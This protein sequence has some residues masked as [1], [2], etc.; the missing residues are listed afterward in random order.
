[1]DI[2]KVLDELDKLFAEKRSGE[3]ENF[4]KGKLRE[5]EEVDD[6]NSIITLVNELIGFYRVSSQY[7][8]AMVYSDYIISLMESL[9]LNNTIPFATT[10]LNIATAYRAAGKSEEALEYYE[11][12]LPIYNEKLAADDFRFASL[13]N[14]ISLVYQ[15]LNKYEKSCECLEKALSIAKENKAEI[16]AA[17]T[18]ANLGISLMKLDKVNEAIKHI[19]KSLTIFEK[20]EGQKDF[21]YPSALAAMGEAQF[22]LKNYEKAIEYYLK[23]L[24]EIKANIGENK[25]YAITCENLSLAY[26][27]AGNTEA[28]QK[29][30]ESAKNAKAKLGLI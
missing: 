25:S 12:V 10:L 30:Y 5:A 20:D 2:K 28:S 4:L 19:E 15:E 21:H 1:M 9:E 26:K 22:K 6:Y 14:N 11:Q 29:Y 24:N 7:N 3:A 17:T 23:S 8:N 13:Y 27:E 18:H 16:E